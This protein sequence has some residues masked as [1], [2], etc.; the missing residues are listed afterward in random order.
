MLHLRNLQATRPNYPLCRSRTAVSSFRRRSDDRSR[1]GGECSVTHHHP[2]RH[3]SKLSRCLKLEPRSLINLSIPSLCMIQPTRIILPVYHT[4]AISHISILNLY[5]DLREAIAA[6]T[7]ITPRLP[8]TPDAPRVL[9]CTLRCNEKK[10]STVTSLFRNFSVEIRSHSSLV[11][12]SHGPAPMSGNT[13]QTSTR[14]R[15]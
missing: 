7:N 11:A 5:D 14:A 1:T 3:H 15:R 4:L 12:R 2:I 10:A 13:M 6:I 8:Q 9:S